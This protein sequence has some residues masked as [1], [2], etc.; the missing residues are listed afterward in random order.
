VNSY[1]DKLFKKHKRGGLFVTVSV[2][3]QRDNECEAVVKRNDGKS[4]TGGAP[5]AW[6][7]Y[8]EEGKMK[9]W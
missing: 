4:V 2:I 3:V 1:V 5:M 7:S 9:T 8:Q 6:C